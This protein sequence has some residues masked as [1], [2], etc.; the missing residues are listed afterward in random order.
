MR[1]AYPTHLLKHD[2]P[3][4]AYRQDGY[5]IEKDGKCVQ[6]ALDTHDRKVSMW[7]EP[8]FRYRAGVDQ[9]NVKHV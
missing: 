4:C 3:G 5:S 6:Q 8:R 7:T 1:L 9:G 2:R